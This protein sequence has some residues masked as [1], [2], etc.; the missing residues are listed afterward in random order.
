MS[1]NGPGVTNPMLYDPPEGQASNTKLMQ[2]VAGVGVSFAA[3][4]AGTALGW[5]SPVLSQLTP[6][7]ENGTTSSNSTDGF[8][9]TAEE[10]S[11]VGSFLAIGAFLGALPAGVLA[12]KIGR[13]Y[14]TMSLAL[15]YLLS[16]ALIIFANGAGMLY[17]G[18]FLIGISTGASCVVA[19]MYIS[20]F[21]EISI[22]GALGAFFQLFLTV[23]ILFVYAIGPYVS[24][25]LLSVMCAVF[26][27]LLIVAMFIVPESPTYLVKTGRRSEAAVALK[28]FWGPNC[29]TQNAVEAIQSDLDAVKGEAKVSDLFT[30]AV[31]RNALFIALLLMFFQQFS[32]INAVIFYTVP[33]FQSAGSTMDPAICGIVVGVVQVLMTFVSSVLIDKAG[34][35]ILLLQ[36]SFIMGSCLVVLGVYFKLQA[37]KADVSGIGWLPLASVVLF[38]ISF[39]LGFGP[40]P[41]MMMGELCA[42]DVKGL[43]SALTVMFNWS[44]VFL[45]T[46]TFGTMQETLGADWTFWFF[47]FWMAVGTLYVFFKVPETKGKTNAEIQ[48]LL[49]AK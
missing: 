8:T 4:S 26:P 9:I 30:K 3:I 21:A 39:S 34:R 35:R 10:G 16:W 25:V 28:W 13:K 41:W 11:W 2:F 12:E 7:V 45:V 5:T 42:P 44:L 27:A 14:T 36:S 38:I 15:P 29:N 1:N 24:W 19:P 33:I 23:G 22:R 37:D 31:N 18:R 49:G 20:E 47:G 40:I 48:A 17:A 32:G 6:V 46:K 43:A